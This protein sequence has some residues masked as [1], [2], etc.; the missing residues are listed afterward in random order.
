[1][2]PRRRRERDKRERKRERISI[3]NPLPLAAGILP[4]LVYIERYA[5]K[6]E[7]IEREIRKRYREKEKIEKA[8]SITNPLP[9]APVILP[10]L[11]KDNRLLLLLDTLQSKRDMPLEERDREIY[12]KK[13]KRKNIHYQPLLLSS[14]RVGRR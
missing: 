11:V 2:P 4:D 13:K 10:D 1:M 7:K 8:I 6:K 3:T 9:L 5:P 14:F 12:K